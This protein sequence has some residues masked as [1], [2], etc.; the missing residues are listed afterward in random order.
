MSTACPKSATHGGVAAL[1]LAAFLS[2]LA[3]VRLDRPFGDNVVNSAL[4]IIGVTAA[5]IFLIDLI[6]AKVHL[7][8]STG[9]DPTFDQPSWQR[10]LIKL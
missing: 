7:R 6:W 2:A 4:F 5:A 9:I 1:G 8:P 3:I 10:T